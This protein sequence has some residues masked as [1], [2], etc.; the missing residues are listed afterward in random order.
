MGKALA[1]KFSKPQANFIFSFRERGQTAVANRLLY[2]LLSSFFFECFGSCSPQCVLSIL[3]I[4]FFG[5]NRPFFSITG[6]PFFFISV[7]RV[8]LS[9]K[10]ECIC[11][12]WCYR[13][14]EIGRFLST[15]INK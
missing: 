10:N 6:A 12:H 11:S 8:H 7:C 9:E 13:G 4:I 15:I 1:T 2:L 3:N 5:E 14:L